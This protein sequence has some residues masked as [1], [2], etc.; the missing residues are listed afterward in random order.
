MG[1]TIVRENPA[2]IH[3][4]VGTV[5]VATPAHVA[6][7][8]GRAQAAFPSW[9]ATPLGERAAAL[10]AGAAAISGAAGEF[11]TLL[12]RELGKVEADCRG[13]TGFAAAWLRWCNEHAGTALAGRDI[14]D[15]AGRLVVHRRPYGVVAAIVPWNAPLILSILKVAPALV[16]GNTVVVKP[17]PLAPL[18]VEQALRALAACLPPGVVEV[19]QGGAETGAALVA[20]PRVAKI[21]FTGGEATGR[22]V[23]RAAAG[24]IT[25]VVLELGGNDPAIFLD[26]ADLTPATM[27][28]ALW[29]T[30]LT[31]GQVCMAAKRLYVHRSRVDEFVEGYL[32]A[33][34]RALVLGDP[35]DPDVTI[36]PMVSASQRRGLVALVAGATGAGAIAHPLGRVAPGADLDAGYFF[37]PVLVT[38]IDPAAPLVVE[39]QF[40]PAVPLVPFDDE[41]ALVA[42]VNAGRYGL[43]S[44]VWSADEDRA[45]TLAARLAC[46]FTFVN[47]HNRS[48][49]SLRAPFGGWRASGYGREFG[50]EGLAEYTQTHAVH[51]PAAVAGAGRAYPT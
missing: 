28:S 15:E 36:G 32:D 47:C 39:E 49:M 4:I 51:R 22:A 41:D 31:S 14:D 26:D 27:T 17:S 3:E 18:A 8:V 11:G 30:F 37:R 44:S 25:P 43:A 19:V 50:P 42:E 38:G 7:A 33:A 45:F 9:S 48:G 24:T 21:A 16:T 23:L 2:R 5:D 29:G 46:G 12:A 20:D 1:E 40:G 6:A 35:L 13:E 34:D 10:E